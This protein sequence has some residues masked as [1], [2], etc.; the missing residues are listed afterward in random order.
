MQTITLFDFCW[1]HGNG[2]SAIL[3]IFANEHES[4]MSIDFE[5]TNKY[6]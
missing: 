2:M 6:I 5:V 1:E 4:T 3:H